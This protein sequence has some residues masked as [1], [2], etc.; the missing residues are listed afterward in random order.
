MTRSRDDVAVKNAFRA[1]PPEK[2]L[3]KH[4]PIAVIVISASE[5]GGARAAERDVARIC[6]S[7]G[8]AVARGYLISGVRRQPMRVHGNLV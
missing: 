4:E 5:R 8:F 7:R 3:G 6:S 2:V 1:V